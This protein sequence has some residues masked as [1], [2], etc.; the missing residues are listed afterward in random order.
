ME[1]VMRW[2]FS[3][4]FVLGCGSVNEDLDPTTD[5]L[6]LETDPTDSDTESPEDTDSETNGTE[7]DG[8]CGQG[9]LVLELGRIGN[10]DMPDPA[11]FTPYA[12]GDPVMIYNGAGGGSLAN[13]TGHVTQA[14]PSDSVLF[15][16]FFVT[17]IDTATGVVLSTR[18]QNLAIAETSPCEGYATLEPYFNEAPERFGDSPIWYE[19]MTG[20]AIQIQVELNDTNGGKASADLS[21][22]WDWEFVDRAYDTGP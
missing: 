3:V 20:A 13:L 17:V 9:S 1:G 19:E 2:L 22:I 16:S 8:E 7:T 21:G 15:L 12:E 10:V 6:D 4:A 14:T 5:T 11:S 18:E